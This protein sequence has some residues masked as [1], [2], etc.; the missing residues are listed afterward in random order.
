[1][2][3][4]RTVAFAVC[5][6]AAASL[7]AVTVTDAG[8]TV[9]I[10]NGII[11][12]SVVKSNGAWNCTL[13]GSPAWTNVVGS[14]SSGG[15][16]SGGMQATI[17]QEDLSDGIGT[18]KR[19]TFTLNGGGT[20]RISVYDNERFFIAAMARS[21]SSGTNQYTATFAS[22]APSNPY[23]WYTPVN[24]YEHRHRPLVIP[25]GTGLQESL[26]GVACKDGDSRPA[27]ILASG[28]IDARG[29]WTSIQ[30]AS[31]GFNLVARSNI[32]SAG[33]GQP[34][35]FVATYRPVHDLQRYAEAVRITNNVIIDTD[36][37]CGFSTWVAFGDGVRPTDVY[38]TADNMVNMRLKDYG[39]TLL[40]IDDG[41]QYGW[42]CSGSW[43]A[44]SEWGG[45]NTDNDAMKTIADQIH[46]RG[47]KAGLWMGVFND[48]DNPDWRPVCWGHQFPQFDP[49]FRG[50]SSCPNNSGGNLNYHLGLAIF[51][52]WLANLMQRVT[53]VGGNN[54]GFDYLKMDFL[55]QGNGTDL[56]YREA[57]RILRDNMRAG[58]Q[59]LHSNSKQMNVIGV[60]TAMRAGDDVSPRWSDGSAGI[61]PTLRGVSYQWYAH[62]NFW[63]TDPDTVHIRVQ[64]GGWGVTYTE[65]QS[66]ATIAG[67]SGGILKMGDKFWDTTQVTADRLHFYKK[68]APPYGV[69]AVP[70]DMFEHNSSSRDYP[71]FFVVPVKKPWG[72]YWVIGVFNWAG[73]AATKTVDFVKCFEVGAQEVM[74]IF[75]YWSDRYLGTHS[76]SLNVTLDSHACKLYAVVP[77]DI[78]R[79]QIV[80]TSRHISQG[81]VDLA[82]VNWD[83]GNKILTGTS[84]RLVTG[85]P[86]TM[87]LNIPAGF[88]LQSATAGGVPMQV[89]AGTDNVTRVT[90][91][92][93]TAVTMNWVL[94]FGTGTVTD[95]TPP[96]QTTTLAVAGVG[97]S[98]VTLRWTAPGDDGN[99][100]TAAQYDIRY[101]TFAITNDTTFNA[102]VQCT[103]EPA[104]LPAGT[105]Q[106]FTVQGLTQGTTYWFALKTAD[107]ASN[108]SPLSNVVSIRTLVVVV[109]TTP[110]AA[111]INLVA[112]SPTFTSML[113]VWTAPG[114]DGN[115]GTAA[116]YDIRYA[117]F[118]ITNDTTFNAAVQ[119]TGEP[120]PLPAGTQQTFTVQGLTQGTTYWFAL[121]TRDEVGNTSALSNVPSR[122]TLQSSDTTPPAQINTLAVIAASNTTVT[123]QWISVGDDGVVGTAAQYDIRYALTPITN[124]ATF[125]AAVQCT[126]EPAPLAAGTPQTFTVTG[127]TGVTTYYFA[128]KA[129][130]E[131]GNWS[132]LSNVVS[133]Q[134]ANNPP[135]V[136]I[137]EP[138]DG[139]VMA[140][141]GIARIS[142]S[143]LDEDGSVIRMDLFV[144]PGSTAPVQLLATNN[145]ATITYLHSTSSTGTFV[146][147]ARA[148]DN[149][150]ATATA[151]VTITVTALPVVLI[152]QPVNGST[153]TA[154]A[155]ITIA[156]QVTPAAG[157]SITE[158]N[159]WNGDSWLA[160]ASVSPYSYTWTG[161]PAG[162]YT[163]R[164]RAADNRGGVSQ[165][166]V[167]VVVYP[168]IPDT[169]TPGIP[170]MEPPVPPG[171]VRV[172][173][174]SGEGYLNTTRGD[175]A[176]IAFVARRT[177]SVTLQ[178][179]TLRG[180]LVREAAVS[181]QAGVR[182]GWSWDGRDAE[183]R[184][185][186]AGVYIVRVAGAGLDVRRKVVVVN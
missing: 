72:N 73:T 122:A 45:G 120:A 80:S 37:P 137:S 35:I 92:S 143:G 40:Q 124:D 23:V 1:M 86:Y 156:A 176:E 138:A 107:E 112:S 32:N 168:V 180:A 11:A 127:L 17:S 179:F 29:Q 75:D 51:K 99:T 43:W 117:T 139:T 13:N 145:G 36:V 153:Y 66:W 141:G 140:L 167:G 14:F 175:R 114:D 64:S 163:L 9:T 62:N 165:S 95:T 28:G 172:F 118:A 60:L 157:A 98:S 90:I 31:N 134:T 81:G 142:A 110:P 2:N 12:V 123:L 129:A 42:R 5:L 3:H 26:W 185:L 102:A 144:S 109:D 24:Y 173:S 148:T 65:A 30:R 183:G 182:H 39:Y 88:T 115:T 177:G 133:T 74:H 25:L 84:T 113:L 147:S 161:V 103:G 94:N 159:F 56:E 49:D 70:I 54:W 4:A 171:E 48:E 67:L 52:T 170:G 135:R 181:A 69:A 10:E 104:P 89:V 6:S 100:G 162:T 186:S 146:I 178:I 131:S 108:I 82:A 111:V 83:A 184:A 125:N 91:T 78:T 58:T 158:V 27:C 76:G 21:G 105:Q 16:T 169:G 8:G 126:G 19:V 151:S 71:N 38:V 46:A 96:A 15:S 47:L 55:D 59:V 22:G 116:Q 50:N 33:E 57:C 77:R 152:T 97:L 164:V 85:V 18:G 68:I 155:S 174:V 61:D 34:F 106:T 136:T 121:K 119:C 79:P 44:R 87:A 53:G 149:A 132:P 41:W 130:D 93:P 128:M 150:G 166:T 20:L 154:P 160:S 7:H 101:A 63:I